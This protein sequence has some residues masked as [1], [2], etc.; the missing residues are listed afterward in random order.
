ML[1]GKHIKLLH[2]VKINSDRQLQYL[3]S[4]RAKMLMAKRQQTSLETVVINTFYNELGG[5]TRSALVLSPK[6]CFN[7]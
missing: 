1:I 6:S 3:Y 7:V 5:T 2:E 4:Q